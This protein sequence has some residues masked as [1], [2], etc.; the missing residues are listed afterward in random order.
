M[1][2]QK[3][4]LESQS[5][6]KSASRLRWRVSRHDLATRCRAVIQLGTIA[7]L[8]ALAVEI[9][10]LAVQAASLTNWNFDPTA[11]QL[12]ISVKDGTTP[13]YFLMAQPA[14][15]VVDLPNTAVGDVSAQQT[16]A[17]AVRQ[18]RVS[19]F[20]PGLTRIV[21][22][23]S[24]NVSLA[25]GQ[26][27]LQKVSD[28]KAPGDARWVLRPLLTQPLAANAP[29]KS[30]TS[31][32]PL[33][34]I[35][36]APIVAKPTVTVPPLAITPLTPAA[37]P[38]PVAPNLLVAPNL[39]VSKDKPAA[40]PQA[41]AMA[42]SKPPS[43]PMAAT[44]E[45]SVVPTPP[46][47]PALA[48]PNPP[49][50][51]ASIALAPVLSPLPSVPAAS[52]PLAT[53]APGT[54]ATNTPLPPAPA[55]RAEDASAAVDTRGGV[56]IAVPTPVLPLSKPTP[57]E[58]PTVGVPPLRTAMQPSGSP[59]SP[60]P[61][62]PS[63]AVSPTTALQ[64][65]R[66]IAPQ[67]TTSQRTTFQRTTALANKPSSTRPLSTPRLTPQTGTTAPVANI[68]RSGQASAPVLNA[69]AAPEIPT[70]VAVMP[71]SSMVTVPPLAPRESVPT[72]AS[73]PLPPSQSGQ[74]EA[75]LEAANAPLPI[76]LTHQPTSVRVAPP[77]RVGT[78][79]LGLPGGVSPAMQATP[80]LSVLP[81]AQ[82]PLVNVPPLQS[83]APPIVEPT[84][85]AI[86]PSYTAS[87]VRQTSSGL[88]PAPL[89]AVPPLQQPVTPIITTPIVTAP[90]ETATYDATTIKQPPVSVAAAPVVE[91][92]QPLPP[93]AKITASSQ[94]SSSLANASQGIR[95][96]VRPMAPN[97]LMPTGAILN[98]RYPG[99]TALNLR[100]DAPQQEVLVLQTE[101]RDTFGNVLAP[102]GSLVTGRF[103]TTTAG[104]RFVTQ[105][106]SLQGRNLPLAAQSDAL[107]GN[108]NV[109]DTN[110]VRNSGIG[111]LAGGVLGAIG[112]AAAGAAATFV[113][114][115]KP[116]TIQPGQIV[117]VRLTQ[118]F[119]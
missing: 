64:V 5:A 99:N 47:A 31:V 83:I 110:L 56:A 105:A 33:A 112:G 17:G 20:T 12:E 69:L 29:I 77:I 76:T 65:A 1:Q 3:L 95:Q 109:K 67:T 88:N 49:A 70:T 9:T 72:A 45:T 19:Q 89:V 37:A 107:D 119:Q 118:D 94:P 14:R 26:V 91:F 34:S 74:A 24:P 86:E 55:D 57:N 10:A 108:R 51:T 98:L 106:I 42:A 61:T 101:I 92:G 35:A 90:V 21:M 7:T 79:S 85:G 46:A 43:P 63:R 38:N 39:T 50:P 18:I 53:P 15:I 13:R 44:A 73:R 71:A 81:G 93:T 78:P 66:A 68:A 23:I 82:V 115:P 104:S 59:I 6:F 54:T 48:A 60:Q 62:T 22:E 8:S 41:P 103:E 36:P 114:A 40:Q 4:E 58:R 16:Y 116:A 32:K 87:T 11:N 2:S 52:T 75:G 113:T 96:A 30:A 27:K 28:D 111:I 97:V 25:P 117:P 84:A 100:P 80:S 102:E